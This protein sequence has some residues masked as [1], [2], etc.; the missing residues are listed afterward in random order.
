MADGIDPNVFL[1]S[2]AD[3]R[4]YLQDT[5][6]AVKD[7][8]HLPDDRTRVVLSVLAMETAVTVL[9]TLEGTDGNA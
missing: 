7:P 4:R 1:K 6:L 3:V 8:K 2:H 9:T 5:L